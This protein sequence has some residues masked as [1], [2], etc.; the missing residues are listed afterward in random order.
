MKNGY[1][2]FFKQA[3]KNAA[4]GS[5]QTHRVSD[6]SFK[7]QEAPAFAASKK[8]R[9]RSKKNVPYVLILSIFL[10]TASVGYL[11]IHV[12]EVESWIAKVEIGFFESS[13]A[14]AD[15]PVSETPTTPATLPAK[16]STADTKTVEAKGTTETTGETEDHLK[17]LAER[18]RQLD[19]REAEL[20]RVEAELEEQKKEL[21][22]KMQ[23]LEQTRRSISSVLE[24]KVKVDDQRIETLVQMYSNMRAPQ[25]AKIF[26]T[27]D[28]TLAIEILG[29]MKK[30]NAAD[31]MN[32][33][34]PEKAQIFS[35]KFAG[36]RNK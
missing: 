13:L 22:K 8:R 32:L 30:K 19:E 18:K 33:I 1:D 28:E 29:R 21:E 20:A 23:E 9:I 15:K 14:Q 25:A 10:A 11:F 36:Y 2:Q 6:L 24:D 17:V 4:S 3:K 27:L 35:E 5:Q 34:K 26:E 16:A 7:T 12:D 31:I